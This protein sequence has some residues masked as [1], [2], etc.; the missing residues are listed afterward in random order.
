MDHG[1][2][3]PEDPKARQERESEG[4]HLQARLRS[5]FLAVPQPAVMAYHSPVLHISASFAVALRYI[6]SMRFPDG[7]DLTV[8]I[9][10]DDLHINIVTVSGR[11]YS[12]S[13]RYVQE[14]LPYLRETPIRELRGEIYSK[15]IAIMEKT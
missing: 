2:S 7:E 15:W 9:L 6:E 3:R 11:E 1:R 5:G 8:D 10:C 12:S 14:R 13:M 4:L